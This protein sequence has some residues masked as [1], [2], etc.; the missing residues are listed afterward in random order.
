MD[1]L[2]SAT[3][4]A[5]DA[6][7][8]L[9]LKKTGDDDETNFPHGLL[10]TDW[11][12]ASLPKAFAIKTLANIKFSKTQLSR[13][14]QSGGFRGGLLGALLNV[15]LP[16]MKNILQPLPKSVLIPLRLMTAAS[17][18]MQES[19]KNL[20]SG[21][22]ALIISDKEMD[23]VMKMIKFPEDS[24]LLL[25]RDTRTVGNEIYGRI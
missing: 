16:L 9:T 24:R 20:E 6:S 10:L 11:R 15:G 13:I 19:I 8:K 12:V 21:T 2:K 3:K 25:K 1:K 17:K 22:T 7:L 18:Q 14:T 23:H 5:T 4:N